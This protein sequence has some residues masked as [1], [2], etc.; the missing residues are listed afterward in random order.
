MLAGSLLTN[1]GN[2]T[3]PSALPLLLATCSALVCG[4]YSQVIGQTLPLQEIETVLR[5]STPLSQRQQ[6]DDLQSATRYWYESKN[7]ANIPAMDEALARVLPLALK[8][9]PMV[10]DFTT[11]EEAQF[12]KPYHYAGATLLT[13][14]Y[15]LLYYGRVK[16]ARESMKLLEESLPYSMILFADRTIIWARRA[17]RYHQHACAIYG[18]I[19]GKSLDKFTF[20]EERDEF[21]EPQQVQ[22]IIDQVILRLR[23]GN[24]PAI[25]YFITAAREHKLRTTAGKWVEDIIFDAVEPLVREAHSEGAWIEAKD[26]IK[27]WQTRQPKS[28]NAR[29]AEAAFLINR[30]THQWRSGKPYSAYRHDVESALDILKQHPLNSPGWFTMNTRALIRNGRPIDEV[31]LCARD[32]MIQ[33]PDH[34]QPLLEAC[35]LLARGDEESTKTCAEFLEVLCQQPNKEVPARILTTLSKQHLLNDIK[36]RLNPDDIVPLLRATAEQ[37]SQSISLRNDFAMLAVDLGVRDTARYML[38]GI[39]AHWSH[40]VWRGKQEVLGQILR[41]KSKSDSAIKTASAAV[42]FRDWLP[43]MIET[44]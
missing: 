16:E 29:I 20:P 39:E 21:D 11:W 19:V 2:Y 41:L 37:W 38:T 9:A 44:K 33:H 13:K 35:Y 23:E 24:W 42:R 26:A 14:T 43:P 32:N 25:D 1:Y 6:F 27:R 7:P 17:L 4:S 10:Q 36:L 8:L 31:M 30:S 15:T 34:A 5:E 40:E 3:M 28:Q 12:V 18:A 22:A